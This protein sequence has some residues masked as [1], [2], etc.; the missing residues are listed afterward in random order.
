MTQVKL[1]TSNFIVI[2]AISFL[3]FSN[4]AIFYNL[5]LYLSSIGIAGNAAGIIMSIFSFSTLIFNPL[6]GYFLTPSGIKKSIII[7][8][9]GM[10]FSL[11]CY[12]YADNFLSLIALRFIHGMFLSL[13]VAATLLEFVLII[14]KQRSGEAFGYISLINILPNAIIPAIMDMSFIKHSV[15]NSAQLYALSSIPLFLAVFLAFLVISKRQ[16]LNI[17]KNSN[18]ISLG[19][20]LFEFKRVPII[21]ISIM[22]VIVFI[23]MSVILFFIKD[24]LNSLHISDVGF[25][26][27]TQM[28]VMFFIRLISKSFFDKIDKSILLFL[29][30]LMIVFGLYFLEVSSAK[31]FISLGAAF[32]GVGFGV[33]MPILNS[34]MLNVSSSKMGAFNLNTIVA[35]MQIGFIIGTMMGSI[36]IASFGFTSVF[37]ICTVLS[38]VGIIMS[39]FLYKN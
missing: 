6:F 20:L 36:L 15:S 34:A 10:A 22:N 33:S 35:G 21:L 11:V 39:I 28:G 32:L 27:L 12:P 4:L 37:G 17:E 3:A 23:I 30:F 18:K 24:F 2:N 1:F 25:F 38:F 7:G 26:F 14:P 9:L 8:I 16:S 19:M 5:H 13:T 29:S 31:F